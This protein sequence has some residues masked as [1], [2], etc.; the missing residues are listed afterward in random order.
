MNQFEIIDIV[1]LVCFLGAILVLYFQRQ[2]P[3][4]TLF[5]LL[6][7]LLFLL[8]IAAAYLDGRA[9]WY[10]LLLCLPLA[11]LL[12]LAMRARP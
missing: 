2:R 7:Y 11:G 9:D 8:A 4:L 3:K 10:M 5:S 12:H 6:P 1:G